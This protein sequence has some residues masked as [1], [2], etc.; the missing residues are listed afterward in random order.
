MLQ[1]DSEL[2]VSRIE[3]D[4]PSYAK[5]WRFIEELERRIKTLEGYLKVQIAQTGELKSIPSGKQSTSQGQRK[6]SVVSDS[7]R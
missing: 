4:I 7:N 2:S 5:I 3:V 1:G 6:K